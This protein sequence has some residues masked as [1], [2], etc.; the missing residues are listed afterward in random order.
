MADIYPS[1][2]PNSKL[3]PV[4]YA[5]SAQPQQAHFVGASGLYWPYSSIEAYIHQSA[6]ELFDL[7]VV[8]QL[9][10]LG[11]RAEF[12]GGFTHYQLPATFAVKP[13]FTQTP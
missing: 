3:S 1:P 7:P 8:Q 2:V 11:L 13:G 5:R 6:P 4:T 12:D 9:D 10:A